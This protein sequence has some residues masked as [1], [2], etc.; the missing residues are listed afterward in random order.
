MVEPGVF[1]EEAQ[2]AA[3]IHGVQLFEEA[4][5]KQP[6]EYAHWKEEAR[7]ARYPPASVRRQAATGNDAMHMRMVCE[8]RA[9][10][11]QDECGTDLRSEMPGIGGDGAQ[12]FG[13]DIEQQPVD[14]GLV[15]IRNRADRS[16][17]CEDHVVVLDG[18]EIGLARFQPATRS[19]SLAPWAMSVAARV[20]GDFD[21]RA[22]FAAQ[23]VPSQ[24]RGAALFDC[25]HDL[26]L[27]EAQVSGLMPHRTKRAK[28]VGHLK[29][30]MR[31]DEG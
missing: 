8:R 5:A 6:R 19:A 4:P 13:R 31:H 14:D 21:R 27:P 12:R 18:Q 1:A 23:H 9:P 11:M 16:R 30:A 15:V 22:P 26:Q 28:D 25:R 10:G 20:V 29:R 24:R 3:A 2:P 17:Q 7:P